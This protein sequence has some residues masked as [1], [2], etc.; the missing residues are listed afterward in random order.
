MSDEY[1]LFV[2]GPSDER[3]IEN[4]I[5]P[6]LDGDITLIKYSQEPDPQVSTLVEGF[7]GMYRELCLLRDFDKGKQDITSIGGRKSFVQSKFPA[8]EDS[9]III[10]AD[11]IEG[12]YLAGLKDNKAS[13][14]GISIPSNTDHISK[15]EFRNRLNQ[16]P[17]DYEINLQKEIIERYSIQ[18]AKEKNNSFDYFANVVGL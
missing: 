10:V 15:K 16:S 2:E 14:L 13:Q 3:F 18:T 1:V 7:Q 17:Y 5:A 8:A 11:A 4:I 9:H 12:W 6:K